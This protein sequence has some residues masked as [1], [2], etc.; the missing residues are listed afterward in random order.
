MMID[1]EFGVIFIRYDRL[2]LPEKAGSRSNGN[3]ALLSELSDV[4]FLE[5]SHQRE[6]AAQSGNSPQSPRIR[7]ILFHKIG[8]GAEHPEGQAIINDIFQ[9]VMLTN[10]LL[11]EEVPD[12][13]NAKGYEFVKWSDLLQ[14]RALLGTEPGR[15]VTKLLSEHRETLGQ[16]RVAGVTVFAGGDKDERKS[17]KTVRPSMLFKIEEFPGNA[18]STDSDPTGTEPD[19]TSS[20]ESINLGGGGTGGTEPVSPGSGE[21]ELIGVVGE[22]DGARQSGDEGSEDGRNPED[23]EDAPMPGDWDEQ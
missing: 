19:F 18:F 5:W 22:D 4:A 9:A 3:A 7:Y 20:M 16:C 6:L 14:F 10:P 13:E 15:I 2:I 11:A 17:P 12:L 8:R 23:D 21:D 1:V